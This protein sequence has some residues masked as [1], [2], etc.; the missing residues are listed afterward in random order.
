MNGFGKASPLSRL[1]HID[2]DIRWNQGVSSESKISIYQALRSGRYKECSL[3]CSA[4]TDADS[5]G[6]GNNLATAACAGHGNCDDGSSEAPNVHGISL[7][8]IGAFAT[9]VFVILFSVSALGESGSSVSS[10]HAEEMPLD[11]PTIDEQ[12]S[13]EN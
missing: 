10:S 1:Q 11:S 13:K 3:T 8:T 12:A 7:P 2:V 5:K 9:A 6:L 4:I